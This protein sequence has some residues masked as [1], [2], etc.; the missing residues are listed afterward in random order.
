MH[1]THKRPRSDTLSRQHYIGGSDI[2]AILGV[3]FIG[4]VKLWEQKTGR[5]EGPSESSVFMD[6]GSELEAYVLRSY[7][8]EKKTLVHEEQSFFWREDQGFPA[9]GSVDG[10]AEVDGELVVVDAKVNC[11]YGFS[12]SRLPEKYRAQAH[13]YMWLAELRTAHFY[14]LHIPAGAFRLYEVPFDEEYFEYLL[15][16]A[17]DFWNHV[18]MDFV[19]DMSLKDSPRAFAEYIRNEDQDPSDVVYATDDVKDA[20]DEY[21]SAR[22]SMKSLE[23][24]LDEIRNALIRV[25]GSSTKIVDFETGETLAKAIVGKADGKFKSLKIT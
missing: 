1:F 25:M 6:V 3:G 11:S 13:W 12:D 17:K 2:G 16:Q 10:I 8:K 14:V 20:I 19:P 18:Q 4:R 23:D 24:A 5:G 21:R 9:G 22:I 7:E 15:R